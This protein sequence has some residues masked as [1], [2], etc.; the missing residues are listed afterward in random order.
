MKKRAKL[1]TLVALILIS[2][3]TIAPTLASAR[4]KIVV[5]DAGHQAKGNSAKEP[6]GPGSS[7]KKAKVSSGTRGIATR[8]PEYKLNLKVALK[9]RTELKKR[10]YKVIMVRTTNNVN[11]SNAERSKLANRVHADLLFR[12]H[13]NG[14]P[15]S[16][17][18]GYLT[19]VPASNRWTKPIV[20]KSLKA[21]NAIHKA[22]LKATGA[23]NAGL[24]KSSNM[25]GFNWSKVPCVIAEMGFMSNKT[26]DRKLQ[27]S[28]Y[29]AKLVKG[30]ANGIDAYFGK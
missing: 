11:I 26:E 15:S 19:M 23:R 5:I 24:A 25:T 17:T 12:I 2:M 20:A 9:L 30:F 4:Q 10:G 6:I 29:Q 18:Q 1:A 7:T 14:S 16:K 27:T 3:L 8:V 22:T 21:G 28:A 13:A